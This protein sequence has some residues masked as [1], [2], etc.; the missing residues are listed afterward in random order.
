V[1]VKSVKRKN[2]ESTI[3]SAST[4]A[5][6]REVRDIDNTAYLSIIDERMK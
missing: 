2:I 6:H 4:H 5:I 1:K 3:N